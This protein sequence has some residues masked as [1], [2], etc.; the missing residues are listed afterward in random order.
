M[1]Y[2][3]EE[4]TAKLI[5]KLYRQEEGIMLAERAVAGVSRDYKKFARWMAITKNR[6]EFEE[7]MYRSKQQGLQEGHAEEKLEIAR[8]MKNAGKPLSE[9]T[10]FTG[11][12]IET[13]K[14]M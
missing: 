12:P 9:I 6:M 14:Q 8:K 10:E 3:H 11:L 7:K 13:I 1:K 2:R 4:Q 5:K